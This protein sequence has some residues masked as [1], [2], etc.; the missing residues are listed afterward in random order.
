MWRRRRDLNS[1]RAINPRWFSR[2]VHSAA[3]P[4]LRRTRR[5]IQSKWV[6]C[7]VKKETL[8]LFAY[9]LS[10]MVKQWVVLCAGMQEYWNAGML[11]YWNAGMQEC[12]NTGTLECRNAG[13]LERWNAEMLKCWNA[14]MLE[15]WNAQKHKDAT[16]ANNK[17]RFHH[18]GHKV[19]NKKNSY[20]I[21][22]VQCNSNEIK[23]VIILF[24][25]SAVLTALITK[26]KLKFHFH[27]KITN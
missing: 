18:E 9:I 11:E 5:I 24:F 1:R 27:K 7:K 13:I 14:G 15:C 22:W 16:R 2:P 25:G 6:T 21:L 4:P 10:K 17:K 19:K 23:E 12:R 3:L 26:A 8:K 20:N